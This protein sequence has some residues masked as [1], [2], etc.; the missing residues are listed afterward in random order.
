MLADPADSFESDEEERDVQ[1]GRLAL[2]P[3]SSQN[4]EWPPFW[5]PFPSE[6]VPLGGVRGIEIS[7]QDRGGT[8]ISIPF[9]GL[10]P[11]FGRSKN[12]RV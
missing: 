12:I 2:G 7:T 3:F 4:S 9:L 6:W 1:G 11:L 10:S 5:P 8:L